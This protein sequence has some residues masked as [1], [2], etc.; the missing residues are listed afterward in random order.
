MQGTHFIDRYFFIV[1]YINILL[2]NDDLIII[3][4]PE[5]LLLSAWFLWLFLLSGK[6]KTLSLIK[7]KSL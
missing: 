5:I 2:N 1:N 6:Y 7:N 4:E 3:R